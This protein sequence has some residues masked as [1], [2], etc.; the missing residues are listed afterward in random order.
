MQ[1][2]KLSRCRNSHASS[3]RKQSDLRADRSYSRCTSTRGQALVLPPLECRP[4]LP[5]CLRASAPWCLKK[6]LRGQRQAGREATSNCT[7]PL[8]MLTCTKC[9]KFKWFK[10]NSNNKS[11]SGRWRQL[12]QQQPKDIPRVGNLSTRSLPRQLLSIRVTLFL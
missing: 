2:T 9:N 5:G 6:R 4:P 10:T 7:V 12:P 8:L 3:A 11:S 1:T